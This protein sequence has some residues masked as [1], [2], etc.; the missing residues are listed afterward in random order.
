MFTLSGVDVTVIHSAERGRKSRVD[1]QRPPDGSQSEER[2]RAPRISVQFFRQSWTTMAPHTRP[3]GSARPNRNGLRV[4]PTDS[5]DTFSIDAVSAGSLPVSPGAQSLW[6]QTWHSGAIWQPPTDDSTNQPE[7]L[8]IVPERKGFPAAADGSAVITSTIP[9]SKAERH[10][11]FDRLIAH[12][13]L[14]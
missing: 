14:V 1:R 13:S 6:S 10:P 7:P 8:R 9:T 2:H 11:G 3:A 5:S 12:P 4:R